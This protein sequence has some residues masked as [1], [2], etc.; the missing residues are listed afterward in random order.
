MALTG[1]SPRKVVPLSTGEESTTRP[2]TPA[3]PSVTTRAFF[4]G[5]VVE[6]GAGRDIDA[7]LDV[8]E[9]VGSLGEHMPTEDGTAPVEKLL[10]PR[11][12]S[13]REPGTPGTRKRTMTNPSAL[14]DVMNEFIATERSYVKRLRTLKEQYADPLRAFAKHKDTALLPLYETKILFG[15]IDAIVPVNQAFLDDLERMIAPKGHLAVGGIGDVCLKHF[16]DLQAF[17]CYKQFYSKREEAQA[18]LKRERLRR[19]ATG[20][21]GFIERIKES[22]ADIRNRVG[23]TELLMDPVQRIPRYT[24]LWDLMIKHMDPEDPQR[25]KLQEAARIAQKIAKCEID[26]PTRRAAVMYCLERTIEGFPAG[27]ISNGRRLLDHIDVDDIQG[28]GFPAGSTTSFGTTS[29]SSGTLHCTLFLFNDKVM[30]VKR[31]SSSVSGKTLS[32]LDQVDKAAKT[33][34]LPTGLK[35]NGLSFKGLID[36]TDLAATDIGGPDMNL[37]FETTP[38]DQSDRWS[39]RPF[40]SYSVVHPPSAVN[41]DPILAQ[42][43][44]QRFLE[45]LWTAQAMFRAKE[46]RSVIL[47]LS[48]KEVES[49]GGKLTL[50][51]TYFNVYQRTA[52]LSEPKKPKVIVHID[53]LGAADDLPFGVSAPP[54]VVIRIQPMAG[55]LCRYS[56]NSSDPNDEGETDI[57][58]TPS[59]P[60]RIV[61]TIHQFGLFKFRTGNNSAPST[62]SASLRSRSGIFGLDAISRNLFPGVMGK[63]GDVFGA[64]L[65]NNSH[66]R[67]KSITS[68]ASTFTTT[69]LDSAIKFSTRST[70]T[71]AT[72]FMMDEDSVMGSPS[73]KHGYNSTV[74]SPERTSSR[75]RARSL[76]RGRPESSVGEST[77]IPTDE[78]EKDLSARLELARKNSQ[79]QNGRP[80]P[81]L[82]RNPPVHDTI[83]ED[84]PPPQ[85]FLRYSRPTTP[86]R[87]MSP[88]KPMSP[89]PMSPMQTLSRPTS[90]MKEPTTPSHHSRMRS[91]PTPAGGSRPMGPRSPSPNP[92][93]RTL[94]PPVRAQS[95]FLSQSISQNPDVS[96][97]SIAIA[98]ESTIDQ[99][100]N[101][102]PLPTSTPSRHSSK[103]SSTTRRTPLESKLNAENVPPVPGSSVNPTEPLTIKKK[104]SVRSGKETSPT[105]KRGSQI[106]TRATSTTRNARRTVP[107]NDHSKLGL[108]E[109]VVI[110]AKTTREDV[111]GIRR[112][113]KRMKIEVATL[114]TSIAAEKD[115]EPQDMGESELSSKFDFFQSTSG[116]PSRQSAAKSEVE[117]RREELRQLV[118]LRQGDSPFRR[119]TPLNSPAKS[120]TTKPPPV[121]SIPNPRLTE[122]TDNVESLLSQADRDLKRTLTSQE[123]LQGDLDA[124]TAELKNKD[125]EIVT[126]KTELNSSRVQTKCLK[127]MMDDADLQNGETLKLFNEELSRLFDKANL[128]DDEA[129]QA[130][131]ME[132]VESK[133]ARNELQ[134]EN[135]SLKIKLAEMELEKER[136]GALLRAHGLIP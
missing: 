93:T 27:L 16:K 78:S 127:N 77:I 54:Y 20:F 85:S 76:S 84:E 133:V 33:G 52:Y 99:L 60:A 128:P 134:K 23:L 79:T 75:K 41:L 25:E 63:G 61:Q 32:G 65:N 124:L 72:S 50:A 80:L 83:Y 129:W 42:S 69:T 1:N 97:D 43:D 45:N 135:R 67:T 118:A 120:T 14:A 82:P 49:R 103:A 66:R 48:E 47:C 74:S 113:V 121:P 108:P 94:Q 64:V 9:F 39:G 24:L 3:A 123:G 46:G 126:L 34:G 87:P 8:R 6:L 31:P 131:G 112:A 71:A 17:D 125:T 36:I 101:G 106:P 28:D 114:K 44:K 4:C 53:A 5:V 73:R 91:L 37:Y 105:S 51:R 19:S 26:D 95:P 81:D 10:E 115:K 30:I 55:E 104:T 59:V 98:L 12:A 58:H 22:T 62:P 57:V 117:A 110:T 116:T 35:K 136:W 122:F 100:K 68:R 132:V 18:I 102:T 88:S 29:S 13:G 38:Q 89:R 7:V 70:S 11:P 56:V 92:G 130:L 109:R 96:H 40:R 15:N 2:H 21:S 90:P 107:L 119:R 111:E 86:S